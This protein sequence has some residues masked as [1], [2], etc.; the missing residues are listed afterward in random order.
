MLD[1]KALAAKLMVRVNP[2]VAAVVVIVFVVLILGF[3]SGVAKAT[4]TEHLVGALA[5]TSSASA[6]GGG[7]SNVANVS[8]DSYSSRALAFGAPGFANGALTCEAQI[9]LVGGTYERA[10]CG[11]L[12]A[13][14]TAH[15]LVPERDGRDDVVKASLCQ[16]SYLR[17]AFTISGKACKE[18]AK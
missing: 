9:P 14:R 3:C 16:N 10:N 18:A 11:A 1:F 5:S 8:G 13:A 15:F 4:G 2:L 17:E 12:T 6:G 7:S